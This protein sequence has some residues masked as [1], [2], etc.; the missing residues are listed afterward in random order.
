[1][2]WAADGDYGEIVL[3]NPVVLKINDTLF[4]HGGLSAKYCKLDID[5]ISERAHDELRDYDPREPGMIEDEYGPL[6][7]RGLAQDAE[8]QRKDML[9]AILERYDARRMVVGH[10]PTQGVVWPRFDGKVV[11]NDVGMAAHYGGHFGY[12]ELKGEEAIAHYAQG[13][14][15]PLPASNDER[16]GYLEQVMAWDPDNRWLKARMR[17][18]Q[19]EGDV[20][21][22]PVDPASLSAD[23]LAV[24]VQA[25][26]WLKPDNCR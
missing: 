4:L 12:L 9:D 1:M 23:E 10:S 15:L 5:E 6:W 14:S 7:Y 22:A 16:K 19:A 2:A 25:E 26:S 11:L 21:N 8:V 24:W 18:L 3:D 13:R 20:A 17:Q